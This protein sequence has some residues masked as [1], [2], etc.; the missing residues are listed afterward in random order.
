MHF[1]FF[2][3]I[4]V[5]FTCKGVTCRIRTS[6]VVVN[7][8]LDCCIS[9]LGHTLKRYKVSFNLN[10]IISVAANEP[11]RGRSGFSVETFS[12]SLEGNSQVT[13][14]T[15]ENCCN[16]NKIFGTSSSKLLLFLMNYIQVISL[17]K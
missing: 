13:N 11:C 7:I 8:L 16:F 12:C 17:R 15:T 5:I 9:K 1:W 10:D 14:E 3:H 2:S 6:Q 4:Y